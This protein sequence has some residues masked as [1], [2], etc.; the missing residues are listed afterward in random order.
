[1]LYSLQ[2]EKHVLGGLIQNP[3]TISDIDRFVSVKDF[4]AEPHGVIY[5]CLR[6]AFLAN[7]K[8]DKVL[9]AQK[10]KNL[11]VAFKD[12][13]NIFD[14]IEAISFAPITPVATID[15]CKELVKLRALRDI[16]GTCEEMKV[17]VNKATNQSLSSTIA[18]VDAVYGKQINSFEFENEPTLLF[19]DIHELVEERGN[20][21]INEIGLETPYPEFNRLYGG[22]RNKN[23]YIIASRAKAGKSSFLNEMS[24]E[25]SRTHKIPV[26]ILDTEMSAAEVKF[27]A[28]AAKSGA[29]L[30]ALETGNWR[31]SANSIEQVR[32]SLPDIGKNYKVYYM[33]IGNKKIEEVASICRRWYLKIVG[34]DNKCLIC[35]DYIKMMEKLEKNQTEY[36][37]MGDLVDTL[38]KLSEELNCPILTAVQSNRMGITTNRESSEVIDDE[39]SIGI[40]DRICWYASYVGILRR[41]TPDE[42]ALDTPES[43]THLLK[44]IVSRF[45]G[46]DATGHQDY[47]QRRYPDGKVR[48][49][50][51]YINFNITNFRVEERGSLRDSIARQNA[52]FLVQDDADGHETEVQRD[53]L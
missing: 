45:E 42:V 20:N 35:Y 44:S 18:E 1:M 4:V 12:E 25:I 31:K 49:V 47:M 52:Q 8:I 40:S 30:W 50:K 13:I 51:N 48:Y 11:G 17:I 9:L 46:R 38:K 53:T 16:E 26:L 3:S 15:A 37:K 29:P 24:S 23:L 28:A 5:G 39:N 10:I 14:Y 41:K 36:Q 2:I 22:L 19:E 33:S 7:E 6:A 43:G 34:R 27:R 32:S 21:P